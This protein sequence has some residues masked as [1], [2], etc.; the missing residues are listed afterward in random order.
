MLTSSRG[1]DPT[2]VYLS[3]GF[4]FLL[5]TIPAGLLLMYLERKAV[6]LR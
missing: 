1:Q 6:I 2:P 5:I 3:I 4:F